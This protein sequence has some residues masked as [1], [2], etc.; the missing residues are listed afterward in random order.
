MPQFYPFVFLLGGMTGFLIMLACYIGQ[1]PENVENA[2]DV[3]IPDEELANCMIDLIYIC[4]YLPS[5]QIQ[6]RDLASL[7][8]R[9]G[10]RAVAA[11]AAIKVLLR[12]N[13]L[14]ARN[15]YLYYFDNKEECFDFKTQTRLNGLKSSLNKTT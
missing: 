3:K 8:N 4:K 12:I 5:G 10:H 6:L 1:D 7:L 13:H 14:A 15:G 9:K 11:M 2:P